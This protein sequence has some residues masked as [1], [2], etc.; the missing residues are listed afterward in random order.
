MEGAEHYREAEDLL[1]NASFSHGITGSPMTREGREMTES[2][3]VSM[4]LRAQVHAT[5][6]LAAAQ[7]APLVHQQMGDSDRITGWARVINWEPAKRKRC[8]AARFIDHS[9]G[10]ER[11]FH[12]PDHEGDHAWPSEP[13]F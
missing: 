1:S 12:E 9:D 4:V 13:P 10:I 3:R 2:T 6:A 5:L 7:V 11:C 8:T